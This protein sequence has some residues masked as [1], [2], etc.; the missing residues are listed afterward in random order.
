[1][2]RYALVATAEGK[3]MSWG[4]NEYAQ[5]GHGNGGGGGG[6][7]GRHVEYPHEILPLSTLN[8]VG[9]AS[10]QFASAAVTADGDVFT[11]VGVPPPLLPSSSD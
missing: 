1:V 2:C 4:H 8:V 6:G 11:W 7:D 3:A 10:G 9:V 5:L